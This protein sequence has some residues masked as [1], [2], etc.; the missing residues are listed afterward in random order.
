[1]T[2]P[3]T[4]RA[5]RRPGMV[6]RGK[7]R[8]AKMTPDS[9]QFWCRV[10]TPEAALFDGPVDLVEFPATAGELGILPGHTPLITGIDAGELRIHAA[11]GVEFWAVAGGFAEIR[12]G[13]IDIIATFVSSGG[14]ES[15]IDA[16]CGRAREALAA[17]D[18]LPPESLESELAMVKAELAKLA[19]RRKSRA[20]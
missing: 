6:R 14:E 19:R 9:G 17:S 20:R 1:M 18:S 12:P 11:G 13:G 5:H 2:A 7:L 16:A 4:S 8:L 3:P 15:E 10:V